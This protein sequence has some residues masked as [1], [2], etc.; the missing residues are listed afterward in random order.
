M[1][2]TFIQDIRNKAAKKNLRVAFPDAED[3]RTLKAALTLRDRKIAQPRLVGNPEAILKIAKD[4]G[5]AL[6]GIPI[7]DPL[8]DGEDRDDVGAG[9]LDEAPA[10]DLGDQGGL[11][12]G[13][14]GRARATGAAR[15][16]VGRSWRFSSPLWHPW[17]PPGVG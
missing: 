4:N 13:G 14:T 17:R 3:V 8:K 16:G 5:L 11:R 7:V 9:R 12:A 6:D 10:L 2:N 1:G 15:A